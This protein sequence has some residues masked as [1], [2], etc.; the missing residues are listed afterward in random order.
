MK[1]LPWFAL[2][3][4]ATIAA[5][6]GQMS[7]SSDAG[8][9]S[10]ASRPALDLSDIDATL[11]RGSELYAGSG[12]CADCHGDRGEGIDGPSLTYGPTAYDIYYQ[13]NT[14]PEMAESRDNMGASNDEVVALAAYVYDLTGT[15]VTSDL[16]AEQVTS[17]ANA[18]EFNEIV[19][20]NYL[21]SAHDQQVASVEDQ[22]V[23]INNW[24]RRAQT[25]NIM[26]SF[27]SR[28]VAT[29]DAGEP[30]FEPEPGKVYF[31]ENTGAG[32]PPGY[33]QQQGEP[34]NSVV[35]GDAGTKE[36]IASYLFPPELRTSMHTTAVTPD[37]RYVYIPGPR[38][39]LEGETQQTTS[40]AQLR[41][42]I[43][44]L[45][46]SATIIKAD[47]L[48]LQPVEQ[49]IVGGRMHHAQ[50]FQ[51]R[52]ML[53]DTFGREDDGLDVFLMD[54]ETNE[55]IGGV[56]DEELGGSTYVA[57]HDNELIYILMEPSGYGSSTAGGYLAALRYNQG[58]YTALRSFWVAVLDPETWE[59][60]RE[61]PYR[62]F[63][64]SWITIDSASEYM[65]VPASAN[66]YVNKI[67][68]ATGATE[69][70]TPTGP[71]PYGAALN[72]DETEIWVADKGE[73]TGMFG[74]TMTVVD[75]ESGRPLETVFAG[76][77]IDH[78]LLA[79]NGREMWGTSNRD[80]KLYVF[81]A[82]ARTMTHE[83][84]MPNFGDAHGLVFVW[85]D[86]EGV[87]HVV[88]DQ[89]GFLS[90]I[91]PAEGRVLDY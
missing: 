53:V 29:W 25:G 35:V 27:Q 79:P 26:R 85:Y 9:G 61:Y 60:V 78:V 58:E 23:M 90:G 82:A 73:T 4:T 50:I 89:G 15:E 28:V 71:G 44:G 57:F 75:V 11:A 12:G 7:A 10:E 42:A 63:R 77:Q 31:Y 91:N 2:A 48:T 84:D 13:L 46:S 1:S 20:D 33:E 22:D 38:P 66:A 67:N 86:E 56:R 88:R 45:D 51:D 59:V 43:P 47:A 72:A 65:Y 30:K 41:Y 64:S 83:I 87:A 80:G 32:R 16:I 5:C 49:I 37:G 40:G 19:P 14:N 6:D 55:I 21:V 39:V 76:Y 34:S 52:Y 62:G 3:C 36:V 81:D 70:T 17:V 69:W 74:R 54:P 24:E 18:R 8:N 68:L